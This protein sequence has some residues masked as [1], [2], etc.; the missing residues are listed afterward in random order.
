MGLDVP[1]FLLHL[2][3]PIS[4]DQKVANGAIYPNASVVA[5]I[6]LLLT[7]ATIAEAC[8]ATKERGSA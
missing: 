2:G 5:D 4:P 7:C 3:P 1:H 6:D 8:R